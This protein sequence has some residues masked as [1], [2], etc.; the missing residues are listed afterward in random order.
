MLLATEQ[1]TFV[2]APLL[3]L[4]LWLRKLWND[5]D[6]NMTE[7]LD[8]EQISRLLAKL[9]ITLSIREIKSY[10]KVFRVLNFRPAILIE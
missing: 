10:L 7:S 5:I 9:K 3:E 4:P 8:I 2:N 1:S 6:V